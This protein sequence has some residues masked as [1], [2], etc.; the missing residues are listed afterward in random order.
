MIPAYDAQLLVFW[1]VQWYLSPETLLP[2][3][4]LHQ[5][6]CETLRP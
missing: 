2:L 3:G 1:P 6:R 5:I 4:I